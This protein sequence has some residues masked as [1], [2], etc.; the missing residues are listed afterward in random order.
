M[1]LQ[2]SKIPQNEVF[3]VLAKILFTQ[4]CIFFFLQHESVN[5]FLTFCR[6]N[7]LG[8]SLVDLESKNL[9]VNENAGFFK[10]EYLKSKLRNVVKFLGVNRAL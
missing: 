4:I 2:G 6:N 1:G 9:K 8:K 3:Q 10:L 7:M 5:G